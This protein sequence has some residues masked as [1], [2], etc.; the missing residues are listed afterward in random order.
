MLNKKIIKVAAAVTLGLVLNST[1]L[2]NATQFEGAL[3]GESPVNAEI[4]SPKEIV[5][6]PIDPEGTV[7]PP[8]DPV[9]TH[10]G[11]GLSLVYVSGLNF[12]KVDFDLNESQTVEAISDSGKDAEGETIEFDNMVTVMDLRDE[13]TDGWNLRASQEGELFNGAVISLTPKVYSNDM[14]V[15]VATDFVLN[16]ATQNF[17]NADGTGNIGIISIGMG[18]VELHVP[19]KTAVGKYSTIIKWDLISEPQDNL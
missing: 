5:V 4:A 2:V 8:V 12:P 16:E 1:T 15:E 14:G 18:K 13:R 19:A 6:P 9:N 17:A 11:D 3:K 7:L 10:E